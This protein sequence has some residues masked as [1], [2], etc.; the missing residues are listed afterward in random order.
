ME[1]IERHKY[2]WDGTEEGWVLIKSRRG[3]LPT[4]YNLQTKM[5]LT[6]DDDRLYQEVVERMRESGTPIL[7]SLPSQG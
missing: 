4:I 5:A 7:D 2:L 1:A 3:R 6:I